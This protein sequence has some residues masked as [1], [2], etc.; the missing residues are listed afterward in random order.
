MFSSDETIEQCTQ[1]EIVSQ[2]KNQI[3]LFHL[4]L[5]YC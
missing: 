2:N 1:Y 3:A 4:Q 5:I